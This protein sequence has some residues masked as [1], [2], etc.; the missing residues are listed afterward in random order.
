MKGVV[1]KISLLGLSLLGGWGGMM[2]LHATTEWELS[3]PKRQQEIRGVVR[4]DRGEGI[5]GVT[6]LVVGTNIGTS[7]AEDGSYQIR[8]PEGKSQVSFSIVG[9]ETRTL[10]ATGPVL[11]VVLQNS[12]TQLEEL[13]IV[14]YGSTTK[15]DL[16]GAVTTVSSKD[17]NTGLVGSSEQLIN[18]KTAGVQVMS[19]SG[20]PTAGST[21]RIRGGASLSASNDPLIV[22][23]GVPLETG[24][25][26]GNSG[27]FLSLINPNDIES[28]TVLKDASSTAIYGS[29][30]SNGVLL[31]TTKKGSGDE[32]RFSFSSIL[33]LQKALGVADMMSRD[34]FADLIN[35][36]GTDAQKALL[37]SVTTN[38]VD[39][40]FQ[41]AM[42][43]DN[44]LS[45]QGKI[46]KTIPFR[47]STGY[48]N[49]QGT[50]R[51]DKTER[52]TGALVVNP[53]FFDQH[54]SVNLNIK[55]ARNNNHFANTD[56]IW[57]A[58]AFNP[59]Q[60]VYS[61][62]DTYGGYY[63]SLDN[64]GLPATGAN[65]NPVGLLNQERHRSKVNRIVGNLDL[66]YKMHFLPELK[67]HVTLGYDYANGDGYNYVPASAANNFLIGGAYD[68]YEQTLTNRL[69]TGYLNYNKTLEELKS[70]IEVT[71]GH[72]Y[73]YWR[74]ERP[75]ITYYN[76]AGDVRSTEIAS[77]ERHALISWYGRLNYQYNDRYLLTATVR[78][79]GTSRFSPDNRWGTFP[80]VALAWRL[81][82]ESFLKPLSFLDDL[83]LRASYGV[84][85][86]Q[87]GIG[88]YEYMSVYNQGTPY[89]Q[90]R[91]GDQ[92]HLVYRPSVYNQD[93][94]W[95]TTKA[96]NYGLDFS[97]LQ[98][99]LSGSAEYYKRK[100]HD[101]IANVPVAAGTNF[102]QNATINVGNVESSGWEFQLNTV[103]LQQE[104]L[105]WEVNF[106]ATKQNIK[107][108]NIAL[109][110]DASSIGT[111]VGPEVSGRGIQILTAGYQPNMFY[112]YKQVYNADGR[113][114]EG[115]YADLNED[116]IINESDLYR[117]HSPAATW[118]FG[119]NTQLSYKKW[120]IATTLRANLGNYV[121]NNTKMNLSA[122]E[123]VQYVDAAINNLH[124]DYFNTGFQSRQY[125]SD[126]YVEK[127]SFLRMENLSLGYN[128][129][130]VGKI[131]N[132]RIGGVIQN[133][134]VITGY[135]GADPEVPNGFDD[136]FYPRSRT[137]SLSL[138][139]DF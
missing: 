87:E 14:G 60:P 7:T 17:F 61:G 16:T 73:Q 35:S 30:A 99:R 112:V 138:N 102:D 40:V 24:G 123:T 31:I 59:T 67:A 34:E 15:K 72:D 44:N 9:Y 12:S 116:G 121:F 78:R 129:G 69:F 71:V 20:S 88:N 47:A 108:T 36:R 96:F 124:R 95:E 4:N 91:F 18:G 41:E 63:E 109:V 53:S 21:I 3:S 25:I 45:L 57:S 114:L 97:F 110:P 101:L 125:Y 51:T 39:E 122:W 76:E 50:L 111:Y 92:Y 43:T 65:R 55:G 80:S 46:A 133:V 118:L 127:A 86:Q 105:R 10:Q 139:L 56:A 13:V 28:M 100:T 58:V 70:T 85:G 29:R 81:S 107:V 54:L 68:T 8:V 66:D 32:L 115:T 137:F 134:F 136:S 130:K 27:N 128:F 126:Y 23:D 93:L 48:Y 98:G 11:N 1:I 119:F 38:W 6:V 26:S 79:D 103:P 5:A 33:S 94:R 104:N 83:K 49:Q 120:T 106:N 74:A 89:A 84:T 42:G 19:N 113:P 64:A 2:E 117:Y 37:G 22:L 132:L 75:P 90:Y 52:I 131:S 82:E 62:A 77:D 135:S